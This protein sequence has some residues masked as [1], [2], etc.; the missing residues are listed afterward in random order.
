MLEEK[1]PHTETDKPERP[2]GDV[3]ELLTTLLD[4]KL[5]HIP[6]D[7]DRILE[8][9]D[10]TGSLREFA[11]HWGVKA[12]TEL[13][14]HA[15]TILDAAIT[16]ASGYK[17]EHKG[18]ER[19]G[20]ES[21][22]KLG[23]EATVLAL[24]AGSVPVASALFGSDLLIAI[25]NLI[26]DK[27]FPG[28][29]LLNAEDLLTLWINTEIDKFTDLGPD[30]VREFANKTPLSWLR[31]ISAQKKID[32]IEVALNRWWW[33]PF[34]SHDRTAI[35]RLYYTSTPPDRAKIYKAI[36]SHVN[37]L[38]GDD[39]RAWLRNLL[40]HRDETPPA[41]AD[42]A[43]APQKDSPHEHQRANPA[44]PQP[45]AHPHQHAS[46]SAH[47]PQ[48]HANHKGAKDT[49]EANL[50]HGLSQFPH[51]DPGQGPNAGNMPG[52]TAAPAAPAS[53]AQTPTAAPTAP[54]GDG[55]P[56]HPL[57]LV[58][59]PVDANPPPGYPDGLWLPGP[60]QDWE[61]Q[62]HDA[63]HS[64]A[65]PGNDNNASPAS[66]DGYDNP[67][68][69]EQQ[70]GLPSQPAQQWSPHD[71]ATLVPPHDPSSHSTAPPG[72]AHALNPGDMTVPDAAPVVPA[73]DG[74]TPAPDHGIWLPFLNPS[75][76]G[77][78]GIAV[79]LHLDKEQLDSL[80]S[81][82]GKLLDHQS[83]GWQ[84]LQDDNN[85]PTQPSSDSAVPTGPGDENLQ[86]LDQQGGPPP[87]PGRQ[88]S[89]PPE[90]TP[91]DSAHP[92]NPDGP[93]AAPAVPAGDGRAPAPDHGV[94]IPFLN[95]SP[96]GPAG[97]AVPLHMD[98]EQLASFD[99]ADSKLLDHQSHG[100]QELHDANSLGQANPD[101]ATSLSGSNAIEADD[102]DLGE[103]ALRTLDQQWAP[104]HEPSSPADSHSLLHAPANDNAA[105]SNVDHHAAHH[106]A[107][108]AH[109]DGHN[110][111]HPGAAADGA[112]HAAH[113][114]GHNALHPGAAA[115][116]AHHAAHHDG[117]NALHPGAAADGAHHA[118]H[119][120]GHNALH[121]GAAAD[122]AHHA[123]HHD[124]HNALHPGAAADGAHHAA[125]HDGH[126]ALHPGAA[127]DGA[128]HAAH[129][130]GHNA[131]HPGAAADGAH[132]AAHHD[133]H[134]ALHPGA[135][136]DGAHHAAHHDGHNALHPGAQHSNH[137]DVAD[138]HGH[139]SLPDHGAWGHD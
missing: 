50:G 33:S 135:A 124:G 66:P 128:H 61:Q 48:F 51:Q 109:H 13:L 103:G 40:Y 2:E 34:T 122:G 74:Q 78:A 80:D 87:E 76:D 132:H 4:K 14:Q 54:A 105:P 90:T 5:D 92:L 42:K 38:A 10:P 59:V 125:H 110:A 26:L 24:A 85:S 138:S 31:T 29:H 37:H 139:N 9:H 118:A 67:Q 43:Q 101:H 71:P 129:H 95:P 116:G 97:I 93:G 49:A 115:D 117:H 68:T 6:E 91:P 19:G 69:L 56:P 52:P 119:H 111:L 106:G 23:A 47:P 3:K 15:I 1:S 77:H 102:D 18:D 108:A 114:D 75:P 8:H 104:P 120:D 64:P 73:V 99:S 25:T 41:F 32:M 136:A 88:W 55:Q 133:G 12:L 100:W 45:P 27:Y 44:H 11:Q 137:S 36:D 46:K 94:W 130:D 123:A 65:Q 21:V 107:D 20:W 126:N 39:N 84:K 79:P 58:W 17:A 62:F 96:D 82:G 30:E 121:P 35:E 53:K 134:N 89:P 131:L 57:Q 112:H 81:A 60:L 86:I 28:H 63:H 7:L 16:A 127:A 72:S 70:E 83:H 22:S 113:H 98:K